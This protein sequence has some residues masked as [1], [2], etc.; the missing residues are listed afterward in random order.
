MDLDEQLLDDAD[1]LIAADPSGSLRALAS[2]GAQVRSALRR[3]TEADVARLERG[4]APAR[5]HRGQP[6]RHRGRR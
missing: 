5:G 1:G 4:R 6:R 2:A 3:P